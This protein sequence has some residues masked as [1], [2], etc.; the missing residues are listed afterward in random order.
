MGD[1]FGV[2]GHHFARLPMRLLAAIAARGV[3]DLRYTSWAGGLA[4]ECLLE[5]GAVASADLCFSSLDIFGLPPRFPRCRRKRRARGARLDGARDDRGA[6]RG[7]E[8]PAEPSLPVARRLGDDGAHP[9]RRQRCRPD[10]RR[11]RRAPSRR[12]RLDTLILHAARADESGN[13]QILGARAL[14][15]AMVGAARKVL[16]TVEEIVP[17][18]GLAEAGRQTVITRNQVT[19]IAH[20]PGGAWPTSSLPFYATDYAAL[21]EAFASSRPLAESLAA[22]PVPGHA[23]AAAAIR[24]ADLPDRFPAVHAAPEAPTVDEIMAVRIAG[25]TRRREFRLGRVRYRRSPMSPIASPRR[26]TP[27]A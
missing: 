25:G 9:R 15:L 20:A 16:V 7:A 24:P 14:D 8:E 4:L 13:V 18:G 5:A 11:G 10:H 19:A 6:A 3:R 1:V 17:V 23:V 22:R 2:G 21:A 12:L 26:R 27:P